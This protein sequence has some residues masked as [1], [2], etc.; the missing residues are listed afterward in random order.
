M[1]NFCFNRD[2]KRRSLKKKRLDQSKETPSLLCLAIKIYSHSCSKTM[3][4]WLHFCAASIS[5]NSLLDVTRDLANW[6]LHQYKH[7]GVF[8]SCNLKKNIFTIIAEDNIDH[9]ARLTTATKLYHGTSFS[10]FQFPS[11]AFPGDMISYSDEFPTTTKLS[12]SKKVDSPPS[13]YTE[14][15]RFISP[16]TLL[17]FLT[18][19]IPALPDIDSVV[20]QKRVKDEYEWLESVYSN[21]S[22]YLVP[23]A[24]HHTGK[25]W[26]VV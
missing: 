16:S 9:N 1:F 3:I 7:E 17:I 18:P 21:K 26:S 25:H 6:I 14:I 13:S 4:N 10:I 11:V 2:G 19:L 5:Y 22:Y 24:K 20:H 8:I 15:W 23:W 12:N